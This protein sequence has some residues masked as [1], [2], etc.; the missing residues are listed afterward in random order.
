M[1]AIILLAIYL[2]IADMIYLSIATLRVN[3]LSFL[4]V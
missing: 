4:L 3:K 2:L 1:I